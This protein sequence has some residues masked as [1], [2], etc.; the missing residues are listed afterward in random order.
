MADLRLDFSPS[1][2]HYNNK[3]RL[4]FALAFFDFS[5]FD[6][7]RVIGI[8]GFTRAPNLTW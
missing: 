8:C 3:C 6:A 1:N 2:F 7:G 4:C 5:R